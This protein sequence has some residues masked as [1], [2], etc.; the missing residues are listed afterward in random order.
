M[1]N[2]EVSAKD[3]IDNKILI[4]SDGSLFPTKPLFPKFSWQKTPTYYMFGDTNKLLTAEEIEFIAQ[5][6]GFLTIE[7]P[8]GRKDFCVPHLC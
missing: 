5:R 1:L 2:F 3:T 6:T 7:K 4:N 8:R